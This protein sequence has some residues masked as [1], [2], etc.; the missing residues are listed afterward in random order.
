MEKY[1]KVET[2]KYLSEEQPAKK[3]DGVNKESLDE[4]EETIVEEAVLEDKPVIEEVKMKR[5]KD[6]I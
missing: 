1:K 5:Y 6:K 3:W 4:A 2:Y